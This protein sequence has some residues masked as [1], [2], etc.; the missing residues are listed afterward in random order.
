MPGP[1]VR[2]LNRQPN[3]NHAHDV[4]LASAARTVQTD[5]AD[6][7]NSNW[8]GAY[9]LLN[10]TVASGTGGL[11]LRIATTDPAS[12]AVFLLN[13]APA[14]VIAPGLTVYAIYPGIATGGVTQAT[15]LMLPDSYRIRVQVGDATSYTYSVSVRYLD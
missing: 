12:G 13:T 15:S 8:L 3:F 4:P 11:I 14:A 6:Q 9:F 5:S 10:V 1:V 7:L 2:S